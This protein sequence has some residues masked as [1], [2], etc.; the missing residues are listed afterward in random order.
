L[1]SRRLDV[2]TLLRS[3]ELFRD[4]PTPVLDMLTEVSLVRAVDPDRPVPPADHASALLLVLA[5]VVQT[6][7][8]TAD[9]REVV[10]CLA[11]PGGFLG[12]AAVLGASADGG[13]RTAWEI[14]ALEQSAVLAI[15]ADVVRMAAERC[16]SLA[17]SLL[18]SA[19][20]RLHAT[21]I[22]LS[23]TLLGDVATRLA[24]RLLEL[25]AIRGIRM[26]KGV[27]ID[28]PLRQEG[29]ARLAGTS[30]ETVNRILA[31]FAANG[32]VKR[33]GERYVLA[34]VEALRARARR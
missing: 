21:E 30:R 32:W 14:R 7:A 31:E 12:H 17:F 6:V 29:L 20:R 2:E 22:C 25:A 13:D 15:P 8:R 26:G 9:G 33:E 24:L 28:I 1:I 34:D 19:A 11:G 27:R 10:L 4:V 23:S 18:V 5:G 16:P 3:N